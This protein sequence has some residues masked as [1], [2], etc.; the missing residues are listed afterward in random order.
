MDIPI[1]PR[2]RTLVL[3]Y[4]HDRPVI[5]SATRDALI[6]NG[7]EGDRDVV[8]VVLHPHDSTSRV[9]DQRDHD[10]IWAFT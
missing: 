2:T 5:E 3:R 10:W 7:M 9:R 8:S 1:G 4:E 6:R